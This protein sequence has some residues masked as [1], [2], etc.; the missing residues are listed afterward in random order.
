MKK[1]KL[2]FVS[3]LTVI[4]SLFCLVGCGTAGKYEAI[5]YKVG[6]ASIAISNQ[7]N[8]SYVELKSDKTAV[9]SIDLANGLL[10]VDGTGTWE[11]KEDKKIVITIEGVAFN[12]TVDGDTLTVQLV[13]GSVV[14]Q[15]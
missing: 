4:I 6:P 2:M 11:E 14:L 8:P 1:V 9:V 13:A 5:S 7:E 12:A 10:K 15:K 3:L